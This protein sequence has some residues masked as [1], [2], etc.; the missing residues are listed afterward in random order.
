MNPSNPSGGGA[1]VPAPPRVW[2]VFV[3][4]AG[5]LAGMQ[6]VGGAIALA[7]IVMRALRE[8]TLFSQSN[9]LSGLVM[10]LMSAPGLTI[11]TV[12]LNEAVLAGTSL[13]AVRISRTTAAARLRTGA[14]RVPGIALVAMIVGPLCAGQVA[15]SAVALLGGM[16]WTLSLRLFERALSKASELELAL[17]FVGIGLAA[18]LGEELFFRGFM[19]TRLSQR[20]G[21]RRA[22]L[23]TAALFG[24]LH[25]DPVQAPIAFLIGLYLGW[26]TERAGSIRPAIAAHTLNNCISVVASRV[27][28][29]APS[30]AE[31]AGTLGVALVVLIV[32][33][34]VIQRR[35]SAQSAG[36]LHP[37]K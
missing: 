34:A 2:P 16:D 22:V 12:L 32:S 18:P 17:L 4:Y 36:P 11:A 29:R 35:T 27:F 8:P 3:T 33:V 1:P 5:V 23:I 7:V 19:Q 14:G 9:D 30:T 21:A 15:A 28:P 26:I 13:A 24:L 10:D 20:W 37:A 6:I 25:L 31:N